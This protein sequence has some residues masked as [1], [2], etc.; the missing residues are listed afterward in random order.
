MAASGL[1]ANTSGLFV[2]PREDWLAQYQ[3]E[4]I[5][6]DAADRR[7]ASSSWSIAPRPGAI[8]CRRLLA[9]IGSGHNIVATVYLEWLSMYR[10]DGPGRVAAGRRGRVR[11][12]RRGD[13]RQRQLR[14]DAG[15]RRHRR[16]CRSA[17]RRRG[18][19]QVL[20]AM[21]AAGGGRFRGIRHSSRP[22][23]PDAGVARHRTL[24]RPEGL[25]HG[26]DRCARASPGLHPLGL[27]FDAWLYSSAARRAG[28]SGARLSRDADRA[29]PCRR[30]DRHR[31]LRRQARRGVRRVERAHPGAGDAART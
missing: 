13:E 31:P 19:D 18:R 2:D 25:L 12:R 20:E 3:E 22:R 29:Q 4:I 9:D 10:A 11:Q 30:R 23:D 14:Q 16:P 5:E 27:S 8:C 21:I 1:P 6:P 28:R 7:S 24:N 26:S 17:A 15:L